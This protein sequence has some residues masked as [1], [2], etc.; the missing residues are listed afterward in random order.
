M[1]IKN[2][3]IRCI[4]C[5]QEYFAKVY[6]LASYVGGAGKCQNPKC[7]SNTYNPLYVEKRK[8]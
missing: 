2:R 1:T 4:H 5:K 8:T 7:P 3:P 6:T